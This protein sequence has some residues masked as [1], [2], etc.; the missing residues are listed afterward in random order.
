MQRVHVADFVRLQVASA[1]ALPGFPVVE[2]D[3]QFVVA[4]RQRAD[5]NFAGQ[6]EEI[7][8]ADADVPLGDAFAGVHV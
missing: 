2:R 6:A 8:W 7:P 3:L 4:G 5:V 1:E